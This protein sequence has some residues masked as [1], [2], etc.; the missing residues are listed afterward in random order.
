MRLRGVEILV[1]HPQVVAQ[2]RSEAAHVVAGRTVESA[3]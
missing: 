3:A 2:R 1:D